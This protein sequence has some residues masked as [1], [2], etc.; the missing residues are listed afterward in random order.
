MDSLIANYSNNIYVPAEYVAG[1]PFLTN[2]LIS[3]FKFS[4]LSPKCLQVSELLT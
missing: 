1:K 2:A 4:P 3:V